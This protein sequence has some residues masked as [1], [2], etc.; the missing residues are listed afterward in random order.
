M[1]MKTTLNLFCFQNYWCATEKNL[2][3]V[4]QVA[5][6]KTK[7]YNLRRV[8]LFKFMQICICNRFKL[9]AEDILP[10]VSTEKKVYTIVKKRI[11]R[12]LAYS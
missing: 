8:S 3:K 12:R 2:V 10:L 6:E 11:Y 9:F 5:F 1:C 7:K 4:H